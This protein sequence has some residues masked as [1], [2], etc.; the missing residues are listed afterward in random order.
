MNWFESQ[1]IRWS[2]PTAIAAAWG[3]RMSIGGT[4]VTMLENIIGVG[5]IMVLL[6]IFLWKRREFTALWDDQ[7]KLL[8]VVRPWTVE[9]SSA[10][11]FGKI[12]QGIDLSHNANRVLSAMGARYRDVT[13]GTVN[14]VVCRPLENG[15]TRVGFVVSRKRLRTVR[16]YQ[17]LESTAEQVTADA[18]VLESALH[19]AYPHT[20]I[21]EANLESMILMK[22]GGVGGI[23]GST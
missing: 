16:T 22:T 15:P 11:L 13:G 19:S 12:P 9:V 14:F 20:P 21:K 4:V 7:R 17:E 2:L 23:V 8:S 6:T 1:Y 10:R 5:F 18:E 3:I